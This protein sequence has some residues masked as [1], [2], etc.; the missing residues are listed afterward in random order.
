MKVIF[1]QIDTACVRI[2]IGGFVI[3]TDPAFDK[4]GGTYQ[5]GSGRSLHKTGS[6]AL[7][8]AHL[9]HVDLVVLSHDQHK[10]NLDNAGREF[11][12]TVPLVISTLEAQDRLGQDNVR[13]IA[14][15]NEQPLETPLVKNLRVTGT[16]ARH[17]STEALHKVAG[18][19]LG[20]VI[21]WDGQENGALYIS[22]DTV[23][24]AG[25][26]EVGRRF[27]IDTALLHIGRAGFPKEIGNEYLTFTTEEAIEA[28]RALKVNKLMPTHMQGWEHFQETPVYTR[29]HIR[30]SDQGPHLVWLTP[31][32]PVAVEI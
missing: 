26:L 22:G 8:P 21:E 1:T 11:I 17:G 28:A 25:V 24:F 32:E 16:P 18:H 2:D 6:P 31:G 20:F 15:W 5:S 27:R 12:K 10:D 14:E 19:V 13:G 7:D 30:E 23:H 29:E 9:G 3:L 4:A